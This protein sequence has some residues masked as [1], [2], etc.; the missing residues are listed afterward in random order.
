RK[1]LKF[2]RAFVKLLKGLKLPEETTAVNLNLRDVGRKFSDLRD[3][4]VRQ[5]L[6]LE[7]KDQSKN[8]PFQ[9]IVE[10]LEKLNQS[11]IKETEHSMLVEKNE[12][13]ALQELLVNNEIINP[14]FALKNP[15]PSKILEVFASCYLKSFNAYNTSIESFDPNLL[16]E[17]RKRL[18]DVQYQFELL[19][20][21]LNSD[22]QNH[23]L[24]IQ[25]LCNVLGKLNDWDMLNHWITSKQHELTNKGKLSSML[26][27][28]LELQQEALLSVAKGRGLNL[29]TY[30]PDQFKDQLF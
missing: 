27:E 9:P 16:H 1:K 8:D 29:Y 21:V 12:F 17:W 26:S 6:L 14:Y 7:L 2:L 20:E 18:K 15:D 4:H 24:K 28:E 10:Q 13:L 25:D 30:T 22:I 11:G 5:L 23:Y 3:A 19:Y